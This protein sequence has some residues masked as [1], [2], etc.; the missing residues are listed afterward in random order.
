MCQGDVEVTATGVV[1]EYVCPTVETVD[2]DTFAMQQVSI[3]IRF[4]AEFR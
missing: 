2:R 3:T 4:T 1:G